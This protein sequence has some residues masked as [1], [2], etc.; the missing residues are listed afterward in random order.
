MPATISIDHRNETTL[1]R[2][3]TSTSATASSPAP[4]AG[5][6]KIPTLSS[7]LVVPLEAVSSSVVL[8]SCGVIAP[9]AARNDDPP[10]DVRIAST[11]IGSAGVSAYR[12][13]VAAAIRTAQ[14]RSLKIITRLRE[15]LSANV[16]RNGVAM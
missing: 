2:N 4:I 7:V 1:R 5:P 12:Q 10:N 8:A 11:K 6:T 16:E 9:S 15:Y 13:R 3:T 14:Y